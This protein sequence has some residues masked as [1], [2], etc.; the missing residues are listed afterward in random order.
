M[1][2]KK[3]FLI[4]LGSI[5]LAIGAVGAVLPLLPS[6]PFLL[7]AAYCFA[8]SSD[9]L[10][11][12]FI[13]TKLYK[14]NLESFLKGQGMTKKAKIRVMITITILMAIGFIMMHRVPVGR[15]ILGFVWLFHMLYFA[16]KVK[17]REVQESKQEIRK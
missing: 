1:N 8:R 3:I 9:K 11:N 13:G 16:F 7:L 6:F 12:W 17:T 5:G 2:P 10:N 15:I 4:V 14:E